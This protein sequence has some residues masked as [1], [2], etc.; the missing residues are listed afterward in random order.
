[1]TKNIWWG[2]VLVGILLFFYRVRLVLAPFFFA[3]VIAYLL[4]PAVT[5]FENKGVPKTAAILLIYACLGVIFAVFFL[6][7]LPKL[8]A[9]LA[10]ILEKLPARVE[11]WENFGAGSLQKLGKIKLPGVVQ[12][13]VNIVM[14]RLELALE[15]LANKAAR[16]LMGAVAVLAALLISPILAFYFLKDHQAMRSRSLQ[17]VPAPYRGEVQNIAREISGALNSFFRG[18]ILISLLVGLL[19]YGGLA[20]LKVPY[21][22]FIGLLAGLFDIIPYFGPIL[23]F[24]PAA[25][26]ALLKSPLTVLWVALL[27]I[28]VNQLESCVIAPKIIG[29]RVGLHPLVVIFA[30]LVGGDLLGVVGML[31]AIPITAILRVLLQYFFGSGSPTG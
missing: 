5:A 17:F 7:F 18:Q 3:V 1:M 26:F 22:L 9:E 25:F 19:I 23:G 6:F 14:E 29:D 13:G 4:Y 24:V 12:D 28:A 11:Q 21:A 2:L 27:F 31:V 20:F 16:G 15:G 10:E 30:I 8:G